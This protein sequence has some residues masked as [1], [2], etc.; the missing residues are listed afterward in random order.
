[1]SILCAC[2]GIK[3]AVSFKKSQKENKK[4]NLLMLFPEDIGLDF[5]WKLSPTYIAVVKKF[6]QSIILLKLS[7]LNIWVR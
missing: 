4:Q 6:W 7:P 2:F 5:S 1:M 3:V